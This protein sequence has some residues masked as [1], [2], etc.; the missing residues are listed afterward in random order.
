MTVF[1][2]AGSTNLAC[3][4]PISARD[5]TLV[6]HAPAIAAAVAE[7]PGSRWW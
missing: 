1:L 2:D 5:V 3:A 7:S 6:T 4:R